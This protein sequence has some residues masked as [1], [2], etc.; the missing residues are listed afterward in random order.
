LTDFERSKARAVLIIGERGAG[1]TQLIHFM[2][3]ALKEVDIS[4]TFR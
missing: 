4:D 1:K 3:N 2:V